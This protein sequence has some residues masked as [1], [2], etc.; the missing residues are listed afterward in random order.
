VLAAWYLASRLRYS[1]RAG[2]LMNQ[3]GQTNKALRLLGRRAFPFVVPPTCR[4]DVNRAPVYGAPDP[5]GAYWWLLTEPIAYDYCE[6]PLAGALIWP[7]GPAS[8]IHRSVCWKWLSAA[9]ISLCSA[10][11]QLLVSLVAV[12]LHVLRRSR[13]VRLC[14]RAECSKD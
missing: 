9:A 13:T 8:G 10:S 4:R 3:D 6:R 1:L 2:C 5:A 14:A 11:S 7:Y 12:F